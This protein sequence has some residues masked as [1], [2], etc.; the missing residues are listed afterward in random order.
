MPRSLVRFFRSFG[1]VSGVAERRRPRLRVITASR[2]DGLR[3]GTETVPEPAAE[4]GCATRQSS[5][6]ETFP[7][8]LNQGR[9]RIGLWQEVD[10]ALEGEIFSKRLDTVAAGVDHL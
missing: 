9:G 7:D 1:M 10:S 2:R 5:N 3:H 4:D 8:H 6:V